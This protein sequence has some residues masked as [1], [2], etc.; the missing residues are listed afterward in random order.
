MGLKSNFRVIF[1]RFFFKCEKSSYLCIL[2]S[3]GF[4][5]RL[6]SKISARWLIASVLQ[7]LKPNKTNRKNRTKVACSSLFSYKS[8]ATNRPWNAIKALSGISK[9]QT[10]TAKTDNFLK[11][12]TQR[13]I[14]AQNK[15]I[16]INNKQHNFNFY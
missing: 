3:R 6:R 11:N 15:P 9:R 4:C 2:N 14:K 8:D 5:A 13:T 12:Y 7:T 10:K 1:C 16:E